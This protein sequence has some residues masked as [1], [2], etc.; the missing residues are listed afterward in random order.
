[1]EFEEDSIISM[2]DEDGNE[3]EYHILAT[4]SETIG[5]GPSECLYM[6][7]EEDSE[8]SSDVMIFKC[9]TEGETE[10]LVFELVDE[11]HDSFNKALALFKQDLDNLGV[12][13]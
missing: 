12:E 6:L 10:E 7:A 11:D 13:Y 3:A 9:V 1:M 2:F 5:G 4:K 8:T